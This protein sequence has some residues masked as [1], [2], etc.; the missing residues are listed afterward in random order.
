[1]QLELAGGFLTDE[2]RAIIDKIKPAIRGEVPWD[3]L[4]DDEEPNPLAIDEAGSEADQ[5]T[6]SG[7]GGFTG[8]IGVNTTDARAGDPEDEDGE[9]DSVSIVTYYAAAIGVMFLLFSMTGAS[10]SILEDEERGTLDRLLMTRLNMSR[11]LLGHWVFYAF[12]GS[13]QLIFMFVYGELVFGIDLFT[14]KHFCGFLLMVIFTAAAAAA[15]GLFLATLCKSRAQLGGLSTIII[16]IMSALGGSMVPR[17]VAPFIETTSKY[18]FN[19]WALDGFLK[20]FW[21]DDPTHSLLESLIYL[22]PQLGMMTLMTIAL[23]LATRQFAKRWET[24]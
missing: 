23:M 22:W 9:S 8:F 19:G 7:L 13:I 20:V 17:M 24:I 1:E 4:D 16:L 11:L 3:S 15:F 2:Q 18:T 10:G 6:D 21:H 12:L 14:L 5:E